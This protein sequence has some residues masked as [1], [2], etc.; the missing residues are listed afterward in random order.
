MDKKDLLFE[1]WAY[2]DWQDKSTEFMFQ[3]MQDVANVSLD[4][5]LNFI[6]K[7][8]KNRKEWYNNNPDWFKKYK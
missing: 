5:V 6:K 3:Y 8:S 2:C 7:E 4:E 1:A